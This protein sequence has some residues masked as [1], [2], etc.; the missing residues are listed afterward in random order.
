MFKIKKIQEI[1]HQIKSDFDKYDEKIS[2][3]KNN[4]IL[5][6]HTPTNDINFEENQNPSLSFTNH[7]KSSLSFSKTKINSAIGFNKSISFGN[8]IN[9]R[10]SQ[11]TYVDTTQSSAIKHDSVSSSDSL[12]FT[13]GNNESLNEYSK[14]ESE[15]KDSYSFKRGRY[16]HSDTT[17]GLKHSA[18][19]IEN[20]NSYEDYHQKIKFSAYGSD[21]YFNLGLIQYK[22]R[23]NRLDV[24][25]ININFYN[26]IASSRIFN[27]CL[28]LAKRDR[29]GVRCNNVLFK[30]LNF[31]SRI[32]KSLYGRESC[33][34]E[35]GKSVMYKE[36]SR[37]SI[38]NNLVEFTRGVVIRNNELTVV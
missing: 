9:I 14:K 30:H 1:N 29:F 2:R 32:S 27:L 22:I 33:F 35:N 10:D 34:L 8:S 28:T 31:M 13:V 36:N 17:I 4:N 24:Q 18:Y 11:N 6:I 38:K 12:N 25:T 20:Q 7:F 15:Y 19:A 21:L 23:L 16:S 5:D 3:K 37:I 26:Y